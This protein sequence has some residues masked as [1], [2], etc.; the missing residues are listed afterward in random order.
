MSL[1]H[2]TLHTTVCVLLIQINTIHT[3][4][5]S[6]G[7]YGGLYTLYSHHEATDYASMMFTLLFFAG[8]VEGVAIATCTI[9]DQADWLASGRQI[10]TQ[11]RTDWLFV[12]YTII[13]NLTGNEIYL[14][15]NT[16]MLTQRSAI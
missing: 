8:K 13:H 4:A 14:V 6:S 12:T 16:H 7:P 2:G 11:P 1:L 3:T 15:N 9:W 5:Y 10:D